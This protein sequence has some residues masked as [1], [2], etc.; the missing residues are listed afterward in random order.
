MV[1]QTMCQLAVVLLRV[2]VMMLWWF[3]AFRFKVRMMGFVLRNA[4]V[5]ARVVVRIRLMVGRVEKGRVA[6]GEVLAE[7]LTQLRSD[8]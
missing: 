1:A 7:I 8:S 6:V 5:Q 4:I 2:F 3:L